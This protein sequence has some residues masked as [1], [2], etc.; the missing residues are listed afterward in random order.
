MN[1][2]GCHITN[3]LNKYRVAYGTIINKHI[4]GLPVTKSKT[5]S[6]ND[7]YEKV[8][9][10]LFNDDFNDNFKDGNYY[11]FMYIKDNI[12]QLGCTLTK[13]NCGECNYREL[14][15][16]ETKYNKVVLEDSD[17]EYDEYNNE[18]EKELNKTLT[19]HKKCWMCIIKDIYGESK[20]VNSYNNLGYK[21]KYNTWFG[22]HYR[23]SEEELIEKVKKDKSDIEEKYGEGI[24]EYNNVQFNGL[25]Y[26][27]VK[28][29][30][31]KDNM[32]TSDD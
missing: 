22:Y 16:S 10:K 17:E 1:C 26:I 19:E 6:I 20:N 8:I 18:Y 2:R 28:Y 32:D 23:Y 13:E 21:I 27:E 4:C 15:C 12:I 30:I 29:A 11:T 31:I 14:K 3:I 5:I 24:W 9:E 25:F 7:D